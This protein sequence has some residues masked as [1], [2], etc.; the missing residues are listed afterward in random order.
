GDR[1]PGPARLPA[2]PGLRP[3]DGRRRHGP[4]GGA[5]APPDT[6]A[7]VSFT[8][9]VKLAVL[10][11]LALASLALAAVEAAFYLL[12]RRRLGHLARQTRGAELVNRYLADPPTLLMPVHMGTYTA[13]MS[14]TLVIAS[15]FLEL[16]AR[17]AL[18][19]AFLAMVI[20]L[21]VFRLTVPYAVVRRNP[22][23]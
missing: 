11:V 9:M 1:R 15:L 19:V 18:V 7:A 6:G 3:R 10:A 17:W 14:M 8:A 2:R 22:E 4:L 13:H 23:R 5:A 20:Y 16:D 12:K 21:L